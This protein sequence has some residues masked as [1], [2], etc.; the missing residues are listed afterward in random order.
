V[1]QITPEEVGVALSLPFEAMPV[2]SLAIFLNDPAIRRLVVTACVEEA[3]DS[4]GMIRGHRDGAIG[5]MELIAA[6]CLTETP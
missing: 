1:S 5:N 4:T 6:L 3:E 2:Q